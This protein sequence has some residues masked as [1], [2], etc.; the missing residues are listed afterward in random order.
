MKR[1]AFYL[2]MLGV[3]VGNAISGFMSSI[4][5]RERISELE[6]RVA[7]IERIEVEHKNAINS[8]ERKLWLEVMGQ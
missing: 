6:N 2:V 7:A 3:L 4:R 8:L 5:L 1:D